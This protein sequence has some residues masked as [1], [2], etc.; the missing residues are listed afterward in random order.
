MG[1]DVPVQQPA[2]PA[3]P[4]Q[5]PMK[6]PLANADVYIGRT[7]Q[8]YMDFGRLHFISSGQSHGC[9][10]VCKRDVLFRLPSNVI[11]HHLE[12]WGTILFTIHFI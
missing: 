4:E 7:G 12:M 6:R 3:Q 8:G 11:V 5:Q 1:C 9:L 2:A 10:V